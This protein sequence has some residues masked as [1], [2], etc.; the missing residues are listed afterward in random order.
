[1]WN[2]QNW[3]GIASQAEPTALCTCKVYMDSSVRWFLLYRL[4]LGTKLM[5]Y[6]ILIFK[7][8]FDTL[9]LWSC[10]I[11][12]GCRTFPLNFIYSAVPVANEK[13]YN[14]KNFSYFFGH[15]CVVD[16]M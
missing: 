12:S 3:E 2:G 1:M 13:I 4:H 14:Q 7:T 5:I 16:L 11:R 10:Y 9:I 6:G 8:L 15:L